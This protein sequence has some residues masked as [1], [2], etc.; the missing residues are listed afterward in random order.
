MLARLGVRVG[1]LD[2]FVPAMLRPGPI[3]LWRELARVAGRVSRDG[4]PEAEMPPA[5]PAA[6]RRHPPGYRSLGKQLVR[7]DMAEKLLREAHEA[8]G[9][10]GAKGGFSLDPA[11]AVSMGLTTESYARLLRL[12]G[13]HPVAPRPLT[14]EAHGPPAPV[15]WRW[16]PPRRQVEEARP[17]PIRT[18]SAFAALAEMVR[19]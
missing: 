5:L 12:A 15:R 6:R 1:A 8:R 13:F 11:R 16:R 2:I 19:Q 18:D 4:A 14:D 10:Q 7:L 3:A 9:S 17:R